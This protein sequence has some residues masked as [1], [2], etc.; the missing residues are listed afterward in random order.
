MKIQTVQ[1]V[2]RQVNADRQARK[3]WE[4]SWFFMAKFL[5]MG[6]CMTGAALFIFW[7]S[8]ENKIFG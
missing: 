2:I 6:L 3:R 8:L 1:D 4:N 5:G 7:W